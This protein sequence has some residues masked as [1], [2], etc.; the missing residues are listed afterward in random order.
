MRTVLLG[1]GVCSPLLAGALAFL[2]PRAGA[3]GR[4]ALVLTGEIGRRAVGLLE[5]R[6]LLANTAVDLTDL[7]EDVRRR[8][9][10]RG[11]AAMDARARLE[12]QRGPATT[13]LGGVV[14]RLAS[15]VRVA[16]ALEWF[17]SRPSIHAV[18]WRWLSR[19]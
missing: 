16:G 1:L 4:D 17:A 14:L 2:R 7:P 12:R 5:A 15:P 18:L 9:V 8:V 6:S 10:T 11:L 3:L 13:T 19:Q